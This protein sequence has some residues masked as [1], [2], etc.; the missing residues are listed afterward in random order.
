[1]PPVLHSGTASAKI[2]SPHV[3]ADASV[4]EH[5]DM[6]AQQILKVLPEPNEI[7]QVASW[8][9]FDEEIQIAARLRFAPGSRAEHAHVTGTMLSGIRQDL[10]APD[11]ESGEVEMGLHSAHSKDHVTAKIGALGGSS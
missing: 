1:V 4:G 6:A 10:P 3:W 7:E 2:R 9:H 11:A 5:V 8:L